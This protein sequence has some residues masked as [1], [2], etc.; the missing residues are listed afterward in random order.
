MQTK[1][2]QI[3]AM[4]TND[5]QDVYTN[6]RTLYDVNLSSEQ[7]VHQKTTSAKADLTF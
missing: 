4:S 3:I 6:K 7:E 2:L 5:E 1:V